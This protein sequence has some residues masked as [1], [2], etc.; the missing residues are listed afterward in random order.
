ME[1][2]DI[3]LLIDTRNNREI[4]EI[5]RL[6]IKPQ[7]VDFYYCSTKCSIIKCLIMA[8]LELKKETIEITK[9]TDN[10]LLTIGNL[11]YI[12]TSDSENKKFFKKLYKEKISQDELHEIYDLIS[13]ITSGEELFDILN[14][15]FIFNISP[16]IAD[17]DILIII[18]TFKNLNLQSLLGLIHSLSD[19][20]IEEI[21]YVNNIDFDNPKE[22]FKYLFEIH[23][24]PIAPQ[25]ANT[26]I[27]YF[28]KDKFEFNSSYD[29][30]LYLFGNL[31]SKFKVFPVGTILLNILNNLD[32]IEKTCKDYVKNMQKSIDNAIKNNTPDSLLADFY[33]LLPATQL[34][35]EKI[36]PYFVFIQQFIGKSLTNGINKENH[37]FVPNKLSESINESI[38]Y[39]NNLIADLHNFKN[40]FSLYLKRKEFQFKIFSSE[41]NCTYDGNKYYCT[42]KFDI[43]SI[44]DILSA[45]LQY[46]I[47]ENKKIKKCDNCNKY[48]I[49]TNKR[50]ELHCDNPSPQNPNYTCKEYFSI[51][52]DE[53]LVK[54][55]KHYKNACNR[56]YTPI[57][58]AK[59]VVKIIQNIPNNLKILKVNIT[60]N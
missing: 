18:K 16:E 11:A 10:D 55:K 8:D 7:N 26:F 1:N 49:T 39:F 59:K 56:F 44:E 2:I 43:K 4:L 42:Y 17:E 47:F 5:N 41:I 14:K 57:S 60:K 29:Y 40:Y 48:F 27:D 34:K 24:R 12:F 15:K 28:H 21:A 51:K 35:L 37:H 31:D 50:D 32:E 13:N 3:K 33:L 19:T 6:I 20:Y 30:F 9:L 58:R 46:I 23:T 36:C 54:I 52:N 38:H 45:S 25:N 53:K 22:I